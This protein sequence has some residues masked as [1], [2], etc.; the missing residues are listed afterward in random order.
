MSLHG[1]LAD[2][3]RSLG[4]DPRTDPRVVAALKPFGLEA[5]QERS[6]VTAASARDVQLEFIREAEAGFQ[7]VFGAWADG[8][9][10]VDG[11]ESTQTTIVGVDGNKV[12]LYLHRPIS[13]TGPVPCVVHLHGGGMTL[14]TAG[15]AGCRQRKK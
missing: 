5:H 12:V 13:S 9:A 10:L 15:S 11:V 4:T 8:T 1:R 6:A 7:T 14:L 2:P 3:S